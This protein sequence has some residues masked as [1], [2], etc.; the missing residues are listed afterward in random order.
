[1]PHRPSPRRCGTDTGPAR[2]RTVS[3]SGTELEKGIQLFRRVE[4][5]LDRIGDPRR[6]RSIIAVG[7]PQQIEFA[8]QLATYLHRARIDIHRDIDHGHIRFGVK[9]R[10]LQSGRDV[11]AAPFAARASSAFCAELR[12][13]PRAGRMR[14]NSRGRSLSDRCDPLSPEVCGRVCP[15]RSR[16]ACIPA[17][18]SR[19]A[20]W[21]RC[22]GTRSSRRRPEECNCRR[23]SRPDRQ[24]CPSAHRGDPRLAPRLWVSP[25][26][27]LS[28]R[29][30][31]IHTY[32]S[33]ITFVDSPG[34]LGD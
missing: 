11:S 33:G 23:Y 2:S 29:R 6:R 25:V 12:V 30:E 20:P 15:Q 3:N 17:D 21:I 19:P 22:R 32:I 18:S 4:V 10:E 28:F 9:P 24:L 27:L 7:H 5:Q 34:E 8:M 13:A 14:S 31:G 1:M 16:T 26:G